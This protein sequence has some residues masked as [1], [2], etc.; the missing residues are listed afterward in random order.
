MTIPAQCIGSTLVAAGAMAG[1]LALHEGTR[2]PKPCIIGSQLAL[3]TTATLAVHHIDLGKAPHAICVAG[4]T[5]ALGAAV[6]AASKHSHWCEEL[7]K[8]PKECV[9]GTLGGVV[10]VIA[11]AL[12]LSRK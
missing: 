8:I 6:F 12:M 2:V 5:A 11:G 7:K 3:A 4:G 1:T 9:A 10:L